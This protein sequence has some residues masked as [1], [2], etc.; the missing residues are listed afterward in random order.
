MRDDERH[1]KVFMVWAGG[2]HTLIPCNTPK[3]VTIKLSGG[4]TPPRL[5]QPLCIPSHSGLWP[6]RRSST[7]LPPRLPQSRAALSPKMTVARA[8]L[9]ETGPWVTWPLCPLH[10][11]WVLGKCKKGPFVQSTPKKSLVIPMMEVA[12]EK[13]QRCR[14]WL[15]WRWKWTHT[16]PISSHEP[17]SFREDV[18]DS[19]VRKQPHIW[20]AAHMSITEPPH[21]ASQS[22]SLTGLLLVLSL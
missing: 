18:A 2:Q 14:E 5:P 20:A 17:R 21:P 22:L 8:G 6:L 19:Q 7:L 12:A 13:S 10:S 1:H 4:R 9:P 15:S 3:Q 16:H 11:G